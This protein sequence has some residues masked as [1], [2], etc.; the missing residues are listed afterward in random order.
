MVLNYAACDDNRS[1]K[2]A[3]VDFPGHTGVP[4]LAQNTNYSPNRV[5]GFPE[6]IRLAKNS[7]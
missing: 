3:L 6:K 2:A 4:S 1:A 5:M 7:F